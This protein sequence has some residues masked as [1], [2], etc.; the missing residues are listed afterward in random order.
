[1]EYLFALLGSLGI[2]AVVILSVLSEKYFRNKKYWNGG[3]CDCGHD[4]EKCTSEYARRHFPDMEEY[5]CPN[6]GKKIVIG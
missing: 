5:V 4:W 1:M 3:H 2:F 6:C